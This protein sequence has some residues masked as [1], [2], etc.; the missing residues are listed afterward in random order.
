MTPET[1]SRVLAALRRQH[2]E[3]PSWAFGNSGTRFKVFAQEGVPR[4]AQ[5]KI[6]DAATQRQ[7]DAVKNLR[8]RRDAARVR[9][10]LDKVSDAARSTDNLMPPIL[11][12]VRSYA[13]IGEICRTLADA[14][15][16]YSECYH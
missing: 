7:C 16:E 6:D 1:R 3:T 12:A 9:Q 11:D 5:E 15:G 8:N 13:T 4:T 2:I 14:F 10:T